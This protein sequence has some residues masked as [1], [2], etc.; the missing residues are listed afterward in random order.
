MCAVRET[1]VR[2]MLFRHCLRTADCAELERIVQLD[3]RRTIHSILGY[4]QGI[5]LIEQVCITRAS[6]NRF[7]PSKLHWPLYIGHDIQ[8]SRCASVV[9]T[10][11]SCRTVHMWLNFHF[12]LDSKYSSVKVVAHTP[13]HWLA[14]CCFVGAISRVHL[15]DR[16]QFLFSFWAN[17]KKRK[18]IEV[19]RVA[20]ASSPPATDGRMCRA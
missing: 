7:P 10:W 1:D 8:Q 13:T 5:K 4:F 16:L 18:M 19:R 6:H 20:Q 15:V 14:K 17:K 12:I 11:F 2:K 9:S 3:E